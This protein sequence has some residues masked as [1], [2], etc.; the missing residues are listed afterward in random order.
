MASYREI[1]WLHS[2]GSNQRN[3]AERYS[4]K[5]RSSIGCIQL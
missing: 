3:I 4:D 5:A 1:L 2:L